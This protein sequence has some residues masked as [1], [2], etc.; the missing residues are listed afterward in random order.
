MASVVGAEAVDLAARA[1]WRTF[2]TLSSVEDPLPIEVMCPAASVDDY[3]VTCARCKLCNA[4][5]RRPP[6]NHIAIRAHGFRDGALSRLPQQ[7]L[8]PGVH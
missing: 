2:R 7:K 3:S 6:K 4:L 1:G 8:W 5:R